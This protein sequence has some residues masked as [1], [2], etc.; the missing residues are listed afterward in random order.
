MSQF[1]IK[2]MSW[3]IRGGDSMVKM[4]A[5]KEVVYKENLDLLVL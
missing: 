5:I 3:N 2:I 4:R 1:E